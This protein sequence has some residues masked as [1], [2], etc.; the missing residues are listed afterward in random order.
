MRAKLLLVGGLVLFLGACT[1]SG[2]TG[3]AGRA[4]PPLNKQLLAGKWKNA[5]KAQF[6]AGYEFAEDGTLKMTVQGMDQPIHGRY[7]WSGERALDLEYPAA[8]EVRQAYQTAAK[9]YKERVEQR[10]KA[11]ELSD[12]AGP[13]LLASVEDD[14]PAKETFRVGISDK[15]R[16]LLLTAENGASRNFEEAE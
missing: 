16:L 2:G 14:L 5:S 13:G 1:G 10:I 7:S 6:I 11:K 12:K 15:P 3:N 8:A 9:A 4:P